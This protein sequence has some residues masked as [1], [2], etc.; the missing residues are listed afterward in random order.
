[1]RGQKKVFLLTG[2]VLVIISALT[3]VFVLVGDKTDTEED[4][5]IENSVT[6][7]TKQVIDYPEED[8]EMPLVWQT[9]YVEDRSISVVYADDREIKRYTGGIVDRAVDFTPETKGKQETLVEEPISKDDMGIIYSFNMDQSLLYVANRLDRGYK[10][11]R[12]VLTPDYAE[13]YLKAPEEKRI[14][15]LVL[16]DKMLMAELDEDVVLDDIDSYFN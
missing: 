13:I 6:Y 4:S 15:I 11:I 8:D 16:P 1:M 10:L 7:V 2:A 5:V 12:K 9:I 3:I 14:R